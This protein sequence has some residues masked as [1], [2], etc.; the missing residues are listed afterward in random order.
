MSVILKG[1]NIPDGDPITI[2]IYRDGSWVNAYT[3]ENGEAV[4]VPN[5]GDLIDRKA[6]QRRFY[7]LP[8]TNIDV[9]DAEDV[10]DVI[11]T[12]PAIIEKGE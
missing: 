7:R 6:L 11:R 8:Q 10:F 5:H 9:I 12:A 2:N 1:L 3:T 4:S